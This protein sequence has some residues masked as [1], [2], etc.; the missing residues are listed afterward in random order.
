[1]NYDKGAAYNQQDI[2]FVSE[3]KRNYH[4]QNILP[5]LKQ[6]FS[7]HSELRIL[8]FG[9]GLGIMAELLHENFSRISYSA[10]DIDSSI[11]ERV[12]NTYP[13][14]KTRQLSSSSELIDFLGSNEYDIILALD[15]WE[16]LPPNEL[17][18]YTRECLGHLTDT[19]LF[20]AQV[21]NLGC[22]FCAN[23][24]FAGDITHCNHF[25]EISARQL[26]LN[27]GALPNDINI[28]PYSFPGGLINMVRGIVRPVLFFLY[29]VFLFFSGLQ[30]LKICTP[31]LIMMVKKDNSN[32]NDR[33][34]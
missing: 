11:L 13:D 23:V 29:K 28:L 18:I 3:L 12:K 20:I 14:T 25:N 17:E 16:H 6:N 2:G 1:M 26:L 15:V 5:L 27:S 22:P 30:V 10:V 8:E 31:N 21:P 34:K 33:K 24:I 7:K 19:G 9:P 4:S 32:V